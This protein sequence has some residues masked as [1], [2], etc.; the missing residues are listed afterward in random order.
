MK[1]SI[2]V[3]DLMIQIILK[4]EI[5]HM[6]EIGL[7]V[8]TGTTLI[9]TKETG[10]TLETNYMTEIHIVE[11]DHETIVEMSIRRNIINIIEGLEIIMKTSMKT[12]MVGI[13]I[14]TITEMT[15]MTKLEIRKRKNLAHMVI[16]V[17]AVFIQ[18]L[19]NCILVQSL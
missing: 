18:N 15:N 3:I 16:K 14:N 6:T 1:I 5:G 11:I 10:P 9:N 12:G 19:K 4:A 13:K 2:I 8:E 7:I 17:V